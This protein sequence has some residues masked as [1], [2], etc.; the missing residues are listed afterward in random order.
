MPLDGGVVG[1]GLQEPKQQ[2]SP[3]LLQANLLDVDPLQPVVQQTPLLALHSDSTAASFL[4][5]WACW[6]NFVPA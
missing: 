6:T 4:V 2:V 3:D 1:A 5:S